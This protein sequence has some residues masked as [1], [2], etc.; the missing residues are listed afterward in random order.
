MPETR[1][2]LRLLTPPAPLIRGEQV[3]SSPE[4]GRS[5]GVKQR[6]PASPGVTP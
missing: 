4:K 3:V 6:S 1:N 2:L 5:G